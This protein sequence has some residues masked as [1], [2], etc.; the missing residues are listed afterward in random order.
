MTNSSNQNLLFSS[1]FTNNVVQKYF[2]GTLKRGK[3]KAEV[4]GGLLKATTIIP[5]QHSVRLM[6]MAYVINRWWLGEDGLCV[7]FFLPVTYLFLI[8]VTLR[9]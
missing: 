1:A 4:Q 8:A 2:N 6:L 5:E 9:V 7:V 3:T